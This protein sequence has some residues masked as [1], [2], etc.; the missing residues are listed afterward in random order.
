MWV[1]SP[2]EH[3]T[4]NGCAVE[5]QQQLVTIDPTTHEE[6][7]PHQRSHNGDVRRKRTR[8]RVPDDCS[9]P[10]ETRRLTVGLTPTLN[11]TLVSE[12]QSWLLGCRNGAVYLELREETSN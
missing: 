6:V 11:L 5:V 7:A 9:T 10:R 2:A 8:L 1:M 3:R 4:Q 12:V